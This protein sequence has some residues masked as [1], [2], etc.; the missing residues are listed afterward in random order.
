[1]RHFE[2]PS[3]SSVTRIYNLRNKILD[4]VRFDLFDKIPSFDRELKKK[5]TEISGNTKLLQQVDVWQ[6]LV[7]GTVEPRTTITSE[8]YELIASE[9][10]AFVDSLEKE[11]ESKD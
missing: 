6:A 3:E 11:L 9:V 1:M 2:I 4:E 10:L 5:V 8:Q 7:G